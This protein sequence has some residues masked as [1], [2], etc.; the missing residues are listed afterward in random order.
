[1]R[2]YKKLYGLRQICNIAV[3]MVH[4]ACTIH[5]LNL[6]ER[7]ARRDVIHGVKHLEEI[8]DDWLCARRTLNILSV[9]ARKW[10]CELP[11]DAA[12]VLKRA[13]EKYGYYSTSEVPSPTSSQGAL[14][15]V[16]D[17]ALSKSSEE[18]SPMGQFSQVQMPNGLDRGSIDDR[19]SLMQSSQMV[20]EAAPRPSQQ[21]QTTRLGDMPLDFNTN[22]MGRWTG[23]PANVTSSGY[24]SQFFP[25]DQ[26]NSVPQ[27]RRQAVPRRLIIPETNEPP[28]GQDWMLTDG[29]RW[30]Q[31]F[32]GWGM[33]SAVP[34][35][36]VFMFNPSR[37]DGFNQPV[38][39]T[40]DD[41]GS[42]TFE[43]LSGSGWL[44]GLD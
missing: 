8:A 39:E 17:D 16:S 4:S 1:M 21:E 35:N 40:Q 15:M 11:E 33:G 6:P 9:L 43:G 32:E 18:H 24:E 7:S 27:G 44:P 31:N 34:P 20:E 28:N 38:G 42:V 13:D 12:F 10:G 36:G 41:N 29:A 25:I 14:G 30:Q 23:N 19:M 37:S 22:L 5:L 26:S 2:L 3:Y